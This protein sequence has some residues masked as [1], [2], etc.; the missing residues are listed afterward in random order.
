MAVE[1]QEAGRKVVVFTQSKRMANLVGER[2]SEDGIS[3]VMFTGDT[4]RTDRDAAIAA[5]TAEDGPGVTAFVSTDAG[6]EG[7]NLQ[8]ANLLVNLDVPWTPGALSQRMARIH[9]VNSTHA[10]FQVLNLTLGGTIEVGILKALENKQDLADAILGE[11]GGSSQ[12]TGR[13]TT[14]DIEA[15]LAASTED[16]S[17]RS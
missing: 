7:L 8:V 6:G 13:R 17:E 14:T 5:F 10:R 1:L 15:L 3:H 4:S 11:A 9:R 16:P 12:L 2:F